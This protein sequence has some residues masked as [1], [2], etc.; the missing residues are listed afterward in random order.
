[1]DRFW[2]RLVWPILWPVLLAQVALVTLCLV[3]GVLLW[4]MMPTHASWGAT[5]W[6]LLAMLLGSSLNGAVFMTL[7]RQ[8]LRGKQRE[9]DEALAGL[10][11]Y[12]ARHH[13]PQR[14]DLPL[15]QRLE[16]LADSCEDLVESWR[17]DLE[18]RRDAEWRLA[19]DLQACKGQ[20]ERLEA[21][22][23]RARED[24][25]I[26]SVFLSHLQ[27][28]LS[29]LMTSLTGV[30]ESD[31]RGQGSGDRDHA[32]LLSL[33]ERLAD[34][35]LLLENL[36]EPSDTSRVPVTATPSGKWRVLIV[37]D[38]PVNLTLARQV[39]ERQGL[40][41]ATATSGDQALSLLEGEPFDLVLMDIFMP[42][43]DGVEAS[44][45]WREREA[46]KVPRRRSILV[47]LTANASDED[48]RRFRQAGMDDCLAKP[49]QPQALVDKLRLW[50][51]ALPKADLA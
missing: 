25:R 27:Q 23:V 12:L 36:G 19:G 18:Q 35:M 24:S 28:S 31:T 16:A 20:L 21:G 41:V 42:G 6:L 15:S 5:L 49:Y 9:V 7:L 13:R 46:D 14:H 34:A 50:L 10:E 51:P 30:L 43:M 22:R 47:A 45:H 8:R 17:G 29:P 26:K 39:L 32:A 2:T 38:G 3:V 11:A 33:R 44:R 4:W 37:D 1:M 48:R 40:E